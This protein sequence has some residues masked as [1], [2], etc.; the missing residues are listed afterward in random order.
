M[1]TAQTPLTPSTFH[2]LLALSLKERHGYEIMKQVEEDSSGTIAMGP[3]TLY[4]AIKRLLHDDFIEET[5]ERPD[6]A[7]DDERRKYYRLTAKG[8]TSLSAELRRLE[9]LVEVGK[10]R[11]LIHALTFAI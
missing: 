8:K 4:G 10:E 1:T 6:P 9:D 3:G 11:K 2:I 7:V 5:G